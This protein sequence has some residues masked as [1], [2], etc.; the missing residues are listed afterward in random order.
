MTPRTSPTR[1]LIGGT[2]TYIDERFGS[3]NF[4][5]RSLRKLFPDH[6]AFLLGEI[7]LYSFVVLLL[8]GTFLS[9]FFEPSAEHV[10]YNGSYENLQG[11]EMSAAYASTL[12]ISF[13]VRGGLLMRQ[14]HHWSAIIFIAGIMV[15]MLR[16]FFTGAFRKP[17]ELNWVI[18][19]TMF[20]LAF[21]NG[22]I[23]YGLP[24]DLLSGIGLKI[25][26]GMAIGIPVVGTYVSFF[27]F[28]G[29]F[30]GTLLI[31]RFYILH[32]LLIPGI[33]LALITAHVVIMWY[34]KHGNFARKRST[35]KTVVGA[36]FYPYF[37]AKTGSFFMF[38]FGVTALMGALVQINPIWLY[39]PYNP[40]QITADSQSDF[41]FGFLEGAVRLMPAWEYSALGH[42][43]TLSIVIPALVIPGLLFTV[44]LLYPFIEQWVTGDKRHHQLLDRP[45]NAPTRTGFGMAGVVFYGVLWAAAGNDLFATTF[46]IPLFATTWFFRIA[47]FVGPVI[48]FVVAKRVC[49]GLQRR[50]RELLEHGV[51][52]GIIK[53]LPSGEFIEVTETPSEEAQAHLEGKKEI[54]QIALPA[55]DDGGVPAPHSRGVRAKLRAALNRLYTRDEIEVVPA[56]HHRG[57]HGEAE[58]RELSS[59][60]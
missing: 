10:T 58:H 57:E 27:L 4:V 17:R 21:A 1:R 29:E 16:V 14:I 54:P 43:L 52:S 44:L 56:E 6:W 49:L 13:D 32:V 28:G 34:Q 59:T 50:D 24:D 5:T 35:E 22:F 3:A 47:L 11:V 40:A 26:Q 46:D 9:F 60:E 41:Y 39:G 45:R 48:A 55:R 8:T 12:H 53:R 7:A 25:T 31:P 19:V 30:P 38:V 37:V 51:E 2:G 15:H 23:G 42:T 36:P 20:I 18:G 33:L